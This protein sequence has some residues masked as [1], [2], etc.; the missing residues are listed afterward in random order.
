MMQE[1]STNKLQIQQ[2]QESS[3]MQISAVHQSQNELRVF[4]DSFNNEVKKLVK[5]VFQMFL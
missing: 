1:I 3:N 2:N 4:C 5:N